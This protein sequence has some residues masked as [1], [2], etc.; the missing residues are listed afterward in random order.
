MARNRTA[1]APQ[2]D[3]ADNTALES[4]ASALAEVAGNAGQVVA[5]MGYEL[6]YNRER[7]VQETRFF[8]GEAAEAMLEAGKRLVLLKEHEQH[9][10]FTRIVED[11]LGIPV[12]TAQQMMQA[13]IKYLSTPTLAGKAQ[14]FAL[15][16]KSKM[17][18]LMTLDD[19]SLVE[20]SEGGSVAGLTLD[21]VD[22]MSVRELKAALRDARADAKAKDDVLATK[23]ATIDRLQTKQAKLRP[24]TPDEDIA[25]IRRETSD[26]AFQAE[27]IIRGSL[28]EGIGELSQKDIETDASQG[29]FV[30]GLL[31]QLERAIAEVR[32]EFGVK[33]KPDGDLTPEWDQDQ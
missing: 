14:T 13:S 1:V 19:D 3:D 22:T 11:Q 5:M 6:T 24:P 16:G 4:G 32:S 30:A 17:F 15:L 33:A 8:M 29:E 9:G 27:A 25:Q 28:R 2:H 31:A 26:Y 10:E 18:E 20:L 7:V 21:D 12:R 23:S